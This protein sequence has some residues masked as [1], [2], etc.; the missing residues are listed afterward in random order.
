MGIKREHT[1]VFSKKEMF[2]SRS[3]ESDRAVLQES[4]IGHFVYLKKK[5]I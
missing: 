5:K 3:K 2:G 1:G 4:E